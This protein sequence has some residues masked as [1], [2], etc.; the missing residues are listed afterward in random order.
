M[1]T[2][3]TQMRD[4]LKDHPEFEQIGSRML[5]QWEL[6]IATSLKAS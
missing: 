2:V 3:S 6:G 5:A 4:Y 1:A